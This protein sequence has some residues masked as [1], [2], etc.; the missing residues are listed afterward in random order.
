LVCGSVTRGPPLGLRDL[1]PRSFSVLVSVAPIFPDLIE[2]GTRR[3]KKVVGA[4]TQTAACTLLR[5][6]LA[7]ELI[8]TDWVECHFPDPVKTTNGQ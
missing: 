8:F 5:W 2:D 1:I 7:V 4:G 6:P 3:I